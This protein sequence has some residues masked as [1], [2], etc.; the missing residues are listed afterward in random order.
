MKI[1]FN[2]D[3]NLDREMWVQADAVGRFSSVTKIPASVQGFHL[4]TAHQG[5]ISP[6]GKW[7]VIASNDYSQIESHQKNITIHHRPEDDDWVVTIA[8]NPTSNKK[9]FSVALSKK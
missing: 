1:T 6:A 2:V 9:D 5:V 3:N 8:L 7:T 4:Y